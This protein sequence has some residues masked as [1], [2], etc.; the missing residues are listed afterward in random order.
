MA[1]GWPGQSLRCHGVAKQQPT[2]FL[3]TRARGIED[4]APATQT[5]QTTQ[6]TCLVGS[7]G[8]TSRDWDFLLTIATA[9]TGPVPTKL[10]SRGTDPMMPT[11]WHE[12]H[13]MLTQ[14]PWFA[15]VGQWKEGEASKQVR[16][17]DSWSDAQIWAKAEISWWCVNEASNVLREFLHTH[18]NKQYQDWNRHF[19]AFDPAIKELINGPIKAALPPKVG[20]PA[21]KK[22]IRS[23]LGRAYVECVYFPLSNMRLV[24]DQVEWFLKGHFPCGW[25]VAKPSAFPEHAMTVVY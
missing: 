20:T 5:L 12:L 22:W 15:N 6:A 13:K 16:R 2:R 9:G 14:C 10:S 7:A 1:F 17:M 11:D 18:H 4:S 25:F 24:Y 19:D 3:T 21:I 23:H 8:A